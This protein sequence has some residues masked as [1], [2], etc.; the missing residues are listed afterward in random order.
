MVIDAPDYGTDVAALLHRGM[1]RAEL[2]GVGGVVKAEILKDDR[3]AAVTVA[4]TVDPRDDAA[5]SLVV[6]G[7]L[8]DGETFSLTSTITD[9]AL[10]V[11]EMGR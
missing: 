4:A 8:V 6:R 2:L 1:T 5:V 9:G 10:L 7:T 3:V 11:Q